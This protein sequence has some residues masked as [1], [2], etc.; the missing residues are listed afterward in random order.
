MKPEM[1]RGRYLALEGTEGAGKTTLVRFLSLWLSERGVRV[2][3]VREPGGTPLGE[4]IRSL[5]LHGDG[6]SEWAEAL[7][8]AAQR[9]ELARRVIA[10]AL[11]AGS[12]VISDRSVYSSLAYQGHARGLGVE[13]VWAVNAAPLGETLPD[14]VLWLDMDPAEALSRQEGQDR[15]GGEGLELHQAVWEGY[16]HLWRSQG[17]KIARLDAS[18]TVSATVGEVAVLLKNRGWV[19]KRRTSPQRRAATP[20]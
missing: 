20:S 8:F 10:P 3:N 11:K 13:N 15:I 6:M 19:V 12:W 17:E 4:S 16:H 7:L 9:S 5:L 1:N 14:L 2:V 18:S